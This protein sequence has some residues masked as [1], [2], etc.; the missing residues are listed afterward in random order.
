MCDDDILGGR[1]KAFDK[2]KL[3]AHEKICRQSNF[4][5]M[6]PWEEE[7][8]PAILAAVVA[9]AIWVLFGPMFCLLLRQR[10]L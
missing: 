8:T 2:F 6:S 1:R 7:T 3:N 9:F 10:L 5:F 4:G